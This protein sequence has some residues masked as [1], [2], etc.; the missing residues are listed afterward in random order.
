MRRAEL[1]AAV[2]LAA[3]SIFLMIKSLE[4]PINWVPKKGPGGGAFPFYMAA[5]ML[6]C[7]V[8]IFVRGLKRATPVTQSDA[9]YLDRQT[10]SLFLVNAGS[11]LVLLALI[12]WVGAYVAIF[13]FFFFYLRMIGR[14]GWPLTA[15][16]SIIGPVSI[17][18]FFEIGMK[19]FLPK[20]ITEPLFYPLYRIFL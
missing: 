11:I 14:H 13:V 10:L 5:G 20:G 15:A 17:F 9:H 19:I 8:L 4:L 6:I 2:V 3:F 12:H 16:V 1:I 18:F 7:C